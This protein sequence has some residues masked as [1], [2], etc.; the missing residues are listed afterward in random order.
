MMTMNEQL[1]RA[2]SRAHGMRTWA[3]TDGRTFLVRSQSQPGFYT[4]QTTQSQI[5]YCDCAGWHYR[6]LCKHSEAVQKRLR[7]EAGAAA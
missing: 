4:V 3:L 6:G 5:D 7:R 1:Q 2:R